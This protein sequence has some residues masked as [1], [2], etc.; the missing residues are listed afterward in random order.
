M[1]RKLDEFSGCDSYFSPIY[2]RSCLKR[3]VSPP[4]PWRQEPAS[5]DTFGAAPP[6]STSPGCSGK[7]M[8]HLQLQERPRLLLEEKRSDLTVLLQ[9]LLFPHTDLGPIHDSDCSN[10]RSQCTVQTKRKEVLVTQSST[11]FCDPMDFSPTDFSVHGILQARIQE[12]V[13]IPFFRG[14]SQPRNQTQVSCVA[15]RHSTI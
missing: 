7:L 2:Q 3:G 11:T 1:T 15:G 4:R 6:P 12:S 8:V 14:S 9:A 5:E 10:W 13:A